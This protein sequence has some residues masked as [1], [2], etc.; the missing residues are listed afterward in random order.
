MYA[1]RDN[2]EKIIKWAK[3]EIR[4]YQKLIEIL[5]VVPLHKQKK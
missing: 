2:P 5:E 3:K 4:E 1:M